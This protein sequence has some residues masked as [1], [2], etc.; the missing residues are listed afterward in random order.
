MT[1]MR[2]AMMAALVAGT[3]G[4][5]LDAH[6]VCDQSGASQADR[7]LWNTHGCWQDFFLWQYRAYDLRSGDWSGR[8]WD[9]ACNNKLEY[10]KHWNGSYLLTYGLVDNND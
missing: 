8:G 1:T 4:V 5:A 9:D 6:A 3:L 10:P 2:K 7:D